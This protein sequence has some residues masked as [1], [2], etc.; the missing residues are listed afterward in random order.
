MTWQQHGCVQMREYLHEYQRPGPHGTDFHR[1]LSS[2]LNAVIQLGCTLT[3][4]TEPAVPPGQ[5]SITGPAAIHVPNFAIV[6]AR[7]P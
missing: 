7:R 2:Y 3:E 5:E 1:P 6:A 4:I